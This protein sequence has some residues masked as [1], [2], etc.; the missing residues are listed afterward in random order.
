MFPKTRGNNFCPPAEKRFFKTM[1]SFFPKLISTDVKSTFDNIVRSFSTQFLEERFFSTNCS[2]GH[3]ECNFDKTDCQIRGH[4]SRK[5]VL[6]TCKNFS[7][8]TFWTIGLHLWQHRLETFCA[9]SKIT[10]RFLL[11]FQ[12]NCT[13]I[14]R[15]GQH[16]AKFLH[17][18]FRRNTLFSRNFTFTKPWECFCDNNTFLADNFWRKPR[19]I[20]W[21]FNHSALEKLRRTREICFCH[22][23]LKSLS[24]Q[25]NK[26][27][28]N[29]FI[30]SRPKVFSR[31][32]ECIFGNNT[33][34]FSVKIFKN[35]NFLPEC[36]MLEQQQ[37]SFCFIS[38]LLPKLF[39]CAGGTQTL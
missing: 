7:Y 4:S 8:K 24:S 18:K 29:Q 12:K 27:H 21:K 2:A 23:Q 16:W 5:K 37:R 28:R 30:I 33:R 22:H 34:G 17:S 26:F 35:F 38:K 1:R 32:V 36:S 20:D 39:L 25:L 13:R 9:I 31:H 10:Y 11:L 14:S 19:E 3:L 15:F 6:E